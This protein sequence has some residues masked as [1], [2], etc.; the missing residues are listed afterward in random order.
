MDI[1]KLLDEI[2]E[3]FIEP[4]PKIKWAIAICS[5]ILWLLMAYILTNI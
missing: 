3:A 5:F 4:Y 1:E 2:W